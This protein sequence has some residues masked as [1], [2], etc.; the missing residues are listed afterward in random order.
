M[1]KKT[2]KKAMKKNLFRKRREK[3]TISKTQE[4]IMSQIIACSANLSVPFR[5]AEDVLRVCSAVLTVTGD[6]KIISLHGDTLMPR[7]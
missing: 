5:P 7:R 4:T 3:E 2:E 6:F 1:K